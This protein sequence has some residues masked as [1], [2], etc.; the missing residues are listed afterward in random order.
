MSLP[1]GRLHLAEAFAALIIASIAVIC[2]AFS[3]R[4]GLLVSGNAAAEHKSA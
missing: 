1:D 3:G 4:E 2:C